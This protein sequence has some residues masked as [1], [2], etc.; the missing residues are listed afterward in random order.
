M[1]FHVNWLLK[2]SCFELFVERKYGLFLNQKVRGSMIFT[3][4]FWLSMIF[5]DLWNM[6][7]RTVW[8]SQYKRKQQIFAIILNCYFVTVSLL[9]KGF[10][11][12]W[13]EKIFAWKKK[14]IFFSERDMDL[15]FPY[16]YPR[17]VLPVRKNLLMLTPLWVHT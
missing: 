2:S 10:S 6:V 4:C 16:P 3:W 13:V 15:V 14:K 12:T 7:F 11:D 1:E 17:F 9:R 5:Q 8:I